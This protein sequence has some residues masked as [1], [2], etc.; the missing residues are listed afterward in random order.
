M[1]GKELWWGTLALTAPVL[2]TSCGV[3]RNPEIPHATQDASQAVQNANAGMARSVRT[4]SADTVG[5]TEGA[6]VQS[7]RSASSTAR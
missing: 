4:R 7:N 6:R 5:T 1:D 3:T 2:L